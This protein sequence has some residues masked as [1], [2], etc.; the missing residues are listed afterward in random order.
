MKNLMKIGFV[1]AL[2]ASVSSCEK[3]KGLFDVDF[4]TTFSGEL[5]IEIPESSLK[6]A[7]YHEFTSETDIDP[8]D[9]EDI[10]E[11][12]DNIEEINVNTILATVVG[13][14]KNDVVFKSGTFFQILDEADTAT[15]TVQ[16]D[17]PI[18]QGTSLTLGE[19]GTDNYE[20]VELIVNRKKQFTI[21]AEGE[22]TQKGVEITIDL[23]IRTTV[24]ANPL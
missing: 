19:L 17:W 13:V 20:K 24:I 7:E 9:D 21:R 22:C 18:V 3:V 8:L 5:D 16:E 15:F 23:G 11:Y 1:L 6:S 4:D 12:Y 2:I 14:N 10:A